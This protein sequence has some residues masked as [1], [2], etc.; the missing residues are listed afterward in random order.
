MINPDAE[1]SKLRMY[2]Q[3]K[4]WY[5]NEIEEIVDLASRDINNIML[6]VISNA[7]AEATEHAEELGADE[8]I[9]EMDVVDFGGGFII[10]TLS[11]KTDF[12]TPAKKMLPDL[13]KHGKVS[14]E[15][16]RYRVIPVGS[17]KEIKQPKNIFSSLQAQQLAQQEARA[18]LLESNID[19]RSTRAKHMAD[20]FRSIMSRRLDDMRAQSGPKTYES[21]GE[22]KFRTASE[23]QD[24]N[25][26]W[27]IPAVKMDMTGYLMDMNSRIEDTISSSISYI[28]ESYEKEFA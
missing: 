12:S 19:N 4:G 16:H 23:K 5:G 11:G 14:E 10:T 9:K 28:I 25:T 1:L 8:F 2:L 15:G 13:V 3:D 27:V 24:P 6:D 18:S 7:V 21:T 26:Q 20:H 17:K 22:V